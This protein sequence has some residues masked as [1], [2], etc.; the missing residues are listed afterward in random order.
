MRF[1]FGPF[2]AKFDS[3]NL[4]HVKLR[5]SRTTLLAILLLI[6]TTLNFT[7]CRSRKASTT[8][9]MTTTEMQETYTELK[10]GMSITA[11]VGQNIWVMG[12]ESNIIMQ[13]MMKG[14]LGGIE[15]HFYLDY[16]N[17]AQIV[18]YHKGLSIPD[19]GKEHKFYGTVGS[20]K[21]PGK[22]SKAGDHTEYY[23]DVHKVE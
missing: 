12:K 3:S 6:S 1:L 2:F 11:H 9:E 18:A 10:P 13:H 19:D 4:N 14:S 23:L 16:H 7:G 8:T 20:M 15:Q 17:G 5:F 21:G 22:N